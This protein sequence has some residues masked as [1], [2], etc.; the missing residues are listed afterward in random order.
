MSG[1]A[2]LQGCSGGV[3]A[4]VTSAAAK[5]VSRVVPNA[6]WSAWVANFKPRAGAQGISPE[7]VSRA[8]EGAGYLP[9]VV[10]LDRNQAEFNRSFEDYLA[11]VASE[12][13]VRAGRAAFASQRGRL[14]AI[15]ARYGVPAQVVAAIW[16]V[17]SS[18]GTRR[19]DI[20]TISAT[21]T[22]A[23]DG[24]RGVFFEGQL[25]AALKILQ[26]GDVPVERMVGSWAGA[27]GHTQFIP[28]SYLAFA[29]DFTGDGRR[30]IWADDPSDALASTAAYLS[31]SGW[32]KG[33]FSAREATDGTLQPDP[34]GPRFAIGPNFRVIK[35]YNNSD[36]YALGVSYLAD[37][38]AGGGPLQTAF[39]PD[40]FGL[41]M[42]DR[43]QLQSRLNARGFDAGTP[44]G[45]FGSKTRAAIA[46]FQRSIGAEPTGTPSR[47]ILDQLG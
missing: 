26:S 25:I 28:T 38:I 45:V 20:P 37:R 33:A 14:Q 19:G 42:A 21:S 32:Q 30:D 23:Y 1:A 46:S 2:A 35:R 18:Y 12:E 31:R 36:S 10:K 41:T 40:K 16:G 6:G 4:P 7:V 34:G 5:P 15:E 17:E 43:K 47:A 11:L 8:F 39:G 9:D 29:V 13:K 22:L 27:M 44:D 24:R 3:V